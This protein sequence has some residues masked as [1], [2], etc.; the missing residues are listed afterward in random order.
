MNALKVLLSLSGATLGV[1]LTTTAAG[2]VSFELLSDLT[3]A[4]FNS[5]TF[6]FEQS[7][8][9]ESRIG[10]LGAGEFEIQILD[11]VDTPVEN[12]QFVWENGEFYD[13]ELNID[14]GDV[15][16]TVA[17]NT[18]FEADLVD[19]FNVLYI[20]AFANMN[21]FP[22]ANLELRDI[23]VDGVAYG[24]TLGPESGDMVEYLKV[25]DIG[26]DA[27]LNVTG[28]AAFFWTGDRPLRSNLAYQ[29]KVGEEGGGGEEGPTPV[30]EPAT[31]SF[32]SLGVLGL[33]MART[34]KRRA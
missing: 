10:D 32:L 16:Y 17:E 26:L 14:S 19:N 3:D 24:P 23:E 33:A 9:G 12:A 29:L 13:F 31:I 6:G 21:L 15:T 28:E 4:E 7:V 2:A 8:V 18:L 20:R 34:R 27:T 5:P 25:S 22:D 1:A 11:D 30:P